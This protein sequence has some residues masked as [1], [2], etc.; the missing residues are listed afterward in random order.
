MDSLTQIVLGAATAEAVAGRKLG[1]KALFWGAVAGTLP[2]LDILV[3]PFIDSVK[4]LS[5][6]RGESH[7]IFYILIFAPLI[8]WLVHKLYKKKHSYQTWCAL[9]LVAMV[10]HPILDAF[11]TF[12]TQLWLPFTRERVAWNS[13]FV[14]DPLY[15]LPFLLSLIVL[16]FFNK[17]SG[18]RRIINWLGLGVS[19]F[20]L[21]F[22]LFNKQT[23]INQFVQGMDSQNIEYQDERIMVSPTPLNN[24]MWHAVAETEDGYYMGLYSKLDDGLPTDYIFVPRNE[25]LLEKYK[26][27]KAL[28]E[29]KWFSK[30]YYT[31]EESINDTLL[32]IDLRFGLMTG[33]KEGQKK[34]YPFKFKLFEKDGKPEIENVRGVEEVDLEFGRV[35]SEFW[36]RLKGNKEFGS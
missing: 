3:Y 15:T 29:L 28:S 21:I 31:V 34:I 9:F 5:V 24:I 13:I 8:A 4:E 35:F 33:W 16:A 27:T 10:T 2:D 25:H 18:K 30:G 20:Y 36:E 6:H 26:G 12:G 17:E 32:F 14:A 23:V 19:T 11:T 22:T 7:A 1:N